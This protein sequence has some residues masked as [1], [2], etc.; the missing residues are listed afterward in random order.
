MLEREGVLA[1]DLATPPGEGGHRCLVI[2]S[3][4]LDVLGSGQQL[5]RNLVLL[6][7]LL[8]EDPQ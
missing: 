6:A 3:N 4:C 1:E 2:G 7:A 5:L 8:Q